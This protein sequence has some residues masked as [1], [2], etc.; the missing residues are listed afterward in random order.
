MKKFFAAVFA[1]VMGISS[2]FAGDVED[3]KAVILK[4]M[5]AGAQGKFAECLPLRTPDYVE[6][7]ES[8]EFTYEHMRWTV[9]AMDGDHPEE[10]L[11]MLLVIRTNGKLQLTPDIRA[12]VSEAARAPEFIENYKASIG[13]L[14]AMLQ[15]DQKLQ[16][17]TTK[18]VSVDI[19]G[20]SATVV[21]EYDSNASG[22]IVHKTATVTLR[23]VNGAWKISK[24]VIETKK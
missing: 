2:L 7:C 11:L 4:D 3:V 23:K 18:F 5:E 22:S 1:C 13:K 8:G 9:L 24:A 19:D 21:G 17:K 12:R 20:D 15:A 10:F 14:A 6:V 16:L